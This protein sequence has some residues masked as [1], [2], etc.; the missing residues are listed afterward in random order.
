VEGDGLVNDDDLTVRMPA[1]TEVRRVLVLGGCGHWWRESQPEGLVLTD[2]PRVCAA[3]PPG[4]WASVGP[5]PQGLSMVRVTY[6]T[7]WTELEIA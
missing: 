3:C 7:A 2:G 4:S 5:S 1:L 6:L